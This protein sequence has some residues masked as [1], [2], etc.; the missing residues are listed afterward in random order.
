MSVTRRGIKLTAKGSAVEVLFPSGEKRLVI[1]AKLTGN[2]AEQD[3]IILN[4]GKPSDYRLPNM[5]GGI[6]R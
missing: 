2:V 1:N 3:E 4:A 5:G 6:C